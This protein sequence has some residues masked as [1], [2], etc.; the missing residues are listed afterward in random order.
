MNGLPFS[1][2]RNAVVRS[3]GLLSV[4]AA[5][6]ALA[7]IAFVVLA[8]RALGPSEGGQVI[9]VFS[10][11]RLAQAA[12]EGGLSRYLTREVARNPGATG[13]YALS[14]MKLI[15]LLAAPAGLLAATGAAAAEPL[16]G[17]T[18]ALGSMAVVFGSVQQ[19]LGGVFLARDR[20]GYD[21]LS[22]I[23]LATAQISGA[24]AAATLFDSP[25][26]FIAVIA[27]ARL[28]GAGVAGASFMVGLRPEVTGRQVSAAKTL[29]ESLPYLLNA[30]G[31]YAYLRVDILILAA[32]AGTQAVAIYGGVADP[33]VTLG[34]AAHVLNAAFL[35]KLADSF[36]V[37]R[38]RFQRLGR[39]MIAVNLVAGAAI[40]GVV[41]VGAGEFVGRLLGADLAAAAD[42]LRVLSVVIVLRFL[43]NAMATWLTADGRQWHRSALVLGAAALNI[44]LNLI[45]VPIWGYWGPVW[46]TLATEALLLLLFSWLLRSEIAMAFGW[47]RLE[48]ER[49]AGA[50]GSHVVA[51]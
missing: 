50:E 24:V 32:I 20:T 36:G 3:A 8:L 39:N 12:V 15:F 31:S 30:L 47:R 16:L 43:N 27:G 51:D 28:A 44:C 22:S 23:T 29:A 21:S 11:V 17:A 10:I 38:P 26:A 34:A 13:A 6:K 2:G 5:A 4:S 46:S 19:A 1:L 9:L 41:F 37:D 35:P 49:V 45:T 18:I 42:V 25:L 40:A 7:S 33:L 48:L 14:S